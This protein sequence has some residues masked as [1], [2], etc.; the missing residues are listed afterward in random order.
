MTLTRNKMR[1]HVWEMIEFC[2]LIVWALIDAPFEY[3]YQ[4]GP[5]IGSYGFWQNMP[6]P[7]IC[8]ELTGVSAAHWREHQNVCKTLFLDRAHSWTL[9]IYCLFYCTLLWAA[10]RNLLKC[11]CHASKRRKMK[12]ATKKLHVTD[13]KQ[14]EMQAQ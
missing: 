12:A 9:L 7:D 8:A 5:R 3:L 14:M 4:H 13:E 11:G 1:T 6:L 2:L 10:W